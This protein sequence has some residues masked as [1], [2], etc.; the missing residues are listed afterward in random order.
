[1][2]Y[3]ILK[4]DNDVLDSFKFDKDKKI[5]TIGRDSDNDLT[6]KDNAISR[7]HAKIE[8][9]DNGYLL[10]DLQSQNGV[11][12]NQNFVRSHWLNNGDKITIGRHTIEF[13]EASEKVVDAMDRTM[14]LDV[15]SY[16]KMRADSFLNVAL[17]DEEKAVK[18]ELFFV[19]QSR[20]NFDLSQKTVTIGKNP[21]SD[22]VVKGFL[23]GRTVATI[24]HG[25]GGHY[26]NYIGGLVKPKVNGITVKES[27]LLRH[28]A[29]IEIGNLKM[30]Y[31]IRK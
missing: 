15:D 11:F 19:D 7:H 12:V 20:K 8:A 18:G 24:T 27:I 4:L 1:M 6:I 22:I 14:V 17:G 26:L 2:I 23:T 5:I 30:K 29:I 10:S 31:V 13:S 16:K 25:V 3:L 28:S 21:A 9:G